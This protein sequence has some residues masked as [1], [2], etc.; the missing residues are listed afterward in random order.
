[1]G[2]P[3]KNGNTDVLVSKILEGAQGA[4]ATTEKIFL[5]DLTIK[6]CDGC[7]S[8]WKGNEC[9]KL[10]DMNNLYP[11]IIES[12]ILIFGTPV[13]WY[14]PTALLKL[15][16]DRFVYFNS[17]ENREIIKE[18]SAILV[19]P[20]EE[21]NLKTAE[22]LIIMFEKSFEYLNLPII[23]TIIVPGVTKRGEV[24]KKEGIMK[25]CYDVGQKLG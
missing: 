1:M 17:P 10:D 23:D 15:F 2:S 7:H 22:P 13:Y 16:L 6:E 12:N 11:K 14:G 19:V 25:K 9:N 8:C 20:F 3:R 21:D 24:S 18:K 4:G 5:V